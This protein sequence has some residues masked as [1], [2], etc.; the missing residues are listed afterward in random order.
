M[1]DY[2]A[3]R[4]AFGVPTPSTNT[5]VQPEY[6]D[7]RPAGVTNHISRMMIPDMPVGSDAD[8][9]RL[10]E[11]IDGGLDGAIDRVMTAKPDHLI[12]GISALSVWGGTPGSVEALK[13]RMRRRAGHGVDVT[14]PAEAVIAALRAYGVRQRV[15]VVEPYYPVIEG[16]LRSF[17]GAHGYE[18][19][20]FNHMRGAQ[21]TQ[22][23][24]LTAQDLIA[25]LR[26]VDSDDVEA[27]VQFGANLPMARIADEAERWLEKPVV[28]VNVATY[29]H[30]L[31]TNG[32]D[33]R[34]RGFTGLFSAH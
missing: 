34:R 25:A 13:E 4:M 32:I 23:S 33:D 8:F 16:P 20:R 30:A 22:Y 3:W 21:P 17:L 31:R 11:A 29:W 2:L 18:V 28:S 10:I 24:V 26:S 15:A 1:R 5:V 7:M 27:I 12:L 9:E 14:V 6:D 19:M